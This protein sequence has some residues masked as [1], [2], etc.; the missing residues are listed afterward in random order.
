MST[1]DAEI[2]SA[3]FDLLC[4]LVSSSRGALEE[5]VYTA[6]LRL[7]HA[8]ERLAELVSP[9][10]GDEER[11]AFYE[12]TAAELGAGSTG[13]Y[14]RSAEDYTAF[15]DTAVG[16]VAAEIRKDNGLG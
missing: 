2:E 15:L 3:A 13:A 4:L 10:A 9:L 8:A 11:R 1:R 6:S 7:I 16:T 12:R 14:L 5:G